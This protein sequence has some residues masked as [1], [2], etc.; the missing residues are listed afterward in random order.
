MPK[1][2][3]CHIKIRKRHSQTKDLGKLK[4]RQAHRNISVKIYIVVLCEQG[5]FTFL[6]LKA[7]FARSRGDWKF[8]WL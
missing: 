2:R 7:I 8:L 4:I 1:Y 5:T 3:Q 6:L